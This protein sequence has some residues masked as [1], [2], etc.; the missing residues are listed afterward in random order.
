[1]GNLTNKT[2]KTRKSNKV[3]ACPVCGKTYA[4]RGIH[5]HVRLAHQQNITKSISL[6]N[7]NRFDCSEIREDI[8]DINGKIDSLI[9][10]II[11]PTLPKDEKISVF[12]AKY[13][14][15]LQKAQEEGNIKLNEYIDKKFSKLLRQEAV[16]MTLPK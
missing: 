10:V 14:G 15:I 3:K 1:M 9:E 13:S 4:A 6:T 11:W 7:E 12:M 16:S 5:S 8:K 2:N